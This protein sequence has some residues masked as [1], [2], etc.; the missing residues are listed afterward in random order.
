MGE[1]IVYSLL[2]WRSLGIGVVVIVVLTLYADD[3]LLKFGLVMPERDLIRIIPH[4]ILGILAG[5]FGPTGY[6]APWRIFWRWIPALNRWLPDLNGVWLGT[7]GSN[8]PTIKKM[9]DGAQA[10]S[11]SDKEELHSTQEQVDAMAVQ[12]TASLF[13]L[14]VEASLS[15]TDGHSHSI[16]AKPHRDQHSGRLHLTYIYEQTSPKPA[17]TDEERHMGAADLTIAPDN[18]NVAEGVYWTRRNWQIGL[19]SAG[20]IA[21]RRAA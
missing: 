1:Q 10:Y 18:L 5:F 8:W 19:N 4:A 12:I 9:L 7:T 3:I 21:L 13:R 14:K 20:R 15:S 17:I 11:V 6:W 2:T 16:T